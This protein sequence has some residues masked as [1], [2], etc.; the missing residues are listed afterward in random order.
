VRQAQSELEGEAFALAATGKELKGEV[1]VQDDA[2]Q[3]LVRAA[4]GKELKG[5]VAQGWPQAWGAAT[6]KELKDETSLSG[7]VGDISK[8]HTQ[9][10]TGKELK[11]ISARA[12]G[13]RAWQQLGKN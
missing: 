1:Q 3:L 13:V 12:R 8:C 2:P 6:G 10:A 7:V 11:A 4:T 9:A 5:K